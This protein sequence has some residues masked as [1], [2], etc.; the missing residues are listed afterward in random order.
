MLVSIE[1]KVVQDIDGSEGE[2][3]WSQ[4]EVIRPHAPAPTSRQLITSSL[5]RLSEGIEKQIKANFDG[6]LLLREW[7]GSREERMLFLENLR[8]AFYVA[9]L[10]SFSQRI[11]IIDQGDQKNGWI[12]NFPGVFQL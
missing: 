9:F 2:G 11:N 5:R 12:N 6:H 8:K 4:T 7:A 3:L 10:T 1:D